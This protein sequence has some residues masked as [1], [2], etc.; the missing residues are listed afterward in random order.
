MELED[1]N[2]KTFLNVNQDELTALRKSCKDKYR[3]LQG[4]YHFNMEYPA[5]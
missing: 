4:I 3:N 2:H 5:V 1:R